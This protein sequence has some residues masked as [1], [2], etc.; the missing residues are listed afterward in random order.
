M[1][2]HFYIGP[3]VVG[4]FGAH[5]GRVDGL[6]G[7]GVMGILDGYPP[8]FSLMTPDEL[9]RIEQQCVAWRWRIK[10]KGYRLSQVHGDFHPWNVLFRGDTDFTVLDRSRGEWG[11]P[12]DDVSSMSINYIF[13]SL[14]Q[15]DIVNGPFRH[16]YDSFWD[17]YLEQTN[18]TEIL[19]VIQPF[20]AWRALVLAHPVWYPNLATAVREAL[21]RFVRHILAAEYFDPRQ[22]NDYLA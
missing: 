7:E 12:A 2:Y 15:S 17:R 11:D 19:S 16:L 8:D 18:D 3:H 20:Y 4:V 6:V 13:F 10:E 1:L 5:N 14:R 9:L 21:F 22:V